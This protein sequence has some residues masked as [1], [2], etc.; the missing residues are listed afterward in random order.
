MRHTSSCLGPHHRAAGPRLSTS[1]CAWPPAVSLTADTRSNRSGG[2][3]A[4]LRRSSLKQS[5]RLSRTARCR[6]SPRWRRRARKS[7]PCLTGAWRRE[8]TDMF[9]SCLASRFSRRAQSTTPSGCSPTMM[10]W[11]WFACRSGHRQ[12]A[13]HHLLGRRGCRYRLRAAFPLRRP[14]ARGHWRK[15]CAKRCA[16]RR[17][18]FCSK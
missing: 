11:R 17:C 5:L 16:G 8:G 13:P 3:G 1:S 9:A 18:V 2:S 15:R 6:R 10:S 4:T 14:M 7:G 12:M